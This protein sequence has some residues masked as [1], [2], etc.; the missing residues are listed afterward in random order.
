M[1]VGEFKLFLALEDSRLVALNEKIMRCEAEYATE[2]IKTG[3]DSSRRVDAPS[4][5]H[6]SACSGGPNPLPPRTNISAP[7]VLEHIFGQPYTEDERMA[8]Q[9][10]CPSGGDCLQED[11][12]VWTTD[13]QKP[14]PVK[15]LLQGQQVLCY[16]H[17]SKG[18]KHA[19]VLNVVATGGV[20]QW[21]TVNLVDG[22]S[23]RVTAD[24]PFLTEGRGKPHSL[25]GIQQSAVRASDLKPHHD[26]VLVMKFV[27]IDVKSTTLDSFE[28]LKEQTRISIDIQHPDR[29]SIFV[30][31]SGQSA[32]EYTMA[33]GA[34]NLNVDAP[35]YTIRGDNTFL[36]LS[37][38][39]PVLRRTNSSPSCLQSTTTATISTAPTGRFSTHISNDDSDSWVLSSLSSALSNAS[40]AKCEIRVSSAVRPMFD[41]SGRID[42]VGALPNADAK[43]NLTD[44]LRLQAS[45]MPSIGSFDHQ[46]KCCPLACWF[47]NQHQYGRRKKCAL[48][49]MCDRCHCDHPLLKRGRKA[50]KAI[51]S[52][53]TK[54]LASL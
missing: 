34:S 45:G 39:R 17:L 32:T 6:G 11:D 4:T 42:Q 21:A 31:R 5:V 41:G 44:Y 33:V 1:E 30:S 10:G 38:E 54:S 47:D 49:I 36:N 26:K 24:H 14:I 37:L 51:D 12:T 13:S 28:D 15:Q 18:L 29:H 40:A 16:D 2:C 3:V 9:C 20:V 23:I 22:T 35:E 25:I 27:P 19:T 8:L 48:G 7:P 50:T 52:P 53:G 46:D 43:V